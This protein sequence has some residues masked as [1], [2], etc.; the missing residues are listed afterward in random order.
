MGRELEIDLLLASSSELVDELLVHRS[1][2]KYAVV[3]IILIINIINIIIITIVIIHALH[4]LPQR[5]LLFLISGKT[6]LTKSAL[7]SSLI[8][9]RMKG[10]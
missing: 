3:I 1:I 6:S 9:S 5:R 2:G 4:P 10:T 7:T 8:H